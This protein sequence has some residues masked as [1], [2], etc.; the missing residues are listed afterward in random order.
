MPCGALIG[1]NSG[2]MLVGNVGS[3]VRLNYTVI[4]D[5]VNVASRLESINKEYGTDIII[6]EETYRLARHAIVARELDSL[7]VYGRQGGLRIYELL[8]MADEGIVLP[9]WATSYDAGLAGYRAH[10]FSTAIAAFQLTL[11]VRPDDRAARI[12]LARCQQFL[13]SPPDK[14]WDATTAMK[15]K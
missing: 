10:E 12:M 13:A 6:G 8:G 3:N 5:A 2:D 7:A 1:I 9:A 4:G 15:V 11:A 14:S